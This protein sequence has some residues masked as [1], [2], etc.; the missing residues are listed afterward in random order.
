MAEKLVTVADIKVFLGITGETEDV[1]LLTYENAASTILE[2]VC[3]RPFESASRTQTFESVWNQSR[4]LV[5]QVRPVTSVTSIVDAD[6]NALTAG[7]DDDYVINTDEGIITLMG[8]QKRVVVV[9]VAGYTTTT[10]PLDLKQ[11]V[12]Y[13]VAQ[14]RSASRTDPLS[15]VRSE[16]Q[17]GVGAISYFSGGTL[18]QPFGEWQAVVDRYREPTI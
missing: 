6:D 8:H 14:L 15:R 13:K 9:Y 11:A 10:L 1:A 2:T 3:N 7:Y 5:L 16:T 17:E 18:A 4:G 12:I